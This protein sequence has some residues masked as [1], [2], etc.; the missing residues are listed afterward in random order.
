MVARRPNSNT[1]QRH[2]T[3]CGEC[4]VAPAS[5]NGR[6][7]TATKF[8]GRQLLNRPALRELGISGREFLRRL[9]NG[10]Y[11][12]IADQ[13]KRNRVKMVVP[14]VRPTTSK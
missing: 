10:D 8:E 9:D 13:V 1:I 5:S 2:R 3:D 4:S 7:R 6:V 14:F 12:F 11:Q